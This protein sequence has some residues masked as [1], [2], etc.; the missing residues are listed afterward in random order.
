MLGVEV[1]PLGLW[2]DLKM[3]DGCYSSLWWRLGVA[4]SVLS[5]RG[6]PLDDGDGHD[7]DDVFLL[8]GDIE[9]V[10]PPSLTYLYR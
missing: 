5:T 1:A 7:I 8:E 2:L 4:G 6:K 3:V 10:Y 9:V